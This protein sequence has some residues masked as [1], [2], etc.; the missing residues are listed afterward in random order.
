MNRK[1]NDTYLID[2]RPMSIMKGI[3]YFDREE[4]SPSKKDVKELTYNK[5]TE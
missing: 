1:N 3:T 2:T 4:M 5:E